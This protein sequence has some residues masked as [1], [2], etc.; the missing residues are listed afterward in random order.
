MSI[1]YCLDA[2][3]A[4]PHFPGIGRYVR[5][6]SLALLDELRDD[7]ELSLLLDPSSQHSWLQGKGAG[8]GR[9]RT[10]VA[11]SSPFSLSQQWALPR[12]L[13]RSGASLYHS[14]Y[15][16]MPYFPGRACILTV[17]DL[18]PLLFPAHVSL[19]ARLFFR[20][21][22]RMALQ[23][24]GH[25]I[26]ISE[27]TRKD[28][29]VR[30][31]ISAGRITVIPLA[32]VGHFRPAS[33]VAIQELRQRYALPEH[34]C[35]Y[36][37]GNKPHK[38]LPRLLQAWSHISKSSRLK[39]PALVLAGMW[40]GGEANLHPIITQSGLGETV[41]I[42]GPVEETDLPALYSGAQ[43]FINPSLYEGFGLPVLEAFACGVPV[44]CAETGGL[45]EVAGDA[46]VRFDPL[47]IESISNAVLSLVEDET[48]RQQK[49][50]AGLQ[51][52]GEF[53][54][55]KTAHQTLMLYR[56]L[57]SGHGKTNA[58]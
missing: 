7:E 42:L 44:A 49:I 36:L 41:H 1:H 23:A 9:L 43:V 25:I 37:G 58:P 20:L 11:S 16:L 28:L 34:Y 13:D 35:L 27:T 57:A 39:P 30:L 2:R 18:I 21:A 14:P 52:S 4:T 38:N 32:A 55:R 17:Y 40:S 53:S 54:W 31:G 6:L 47:S 24:A 8:A 50:N 33:Q 5:N 51:R 26:A 56:R 48:L 22:L 19:R 10:A 12:Q 3:T 29:R 45:V 46:A 15:Y